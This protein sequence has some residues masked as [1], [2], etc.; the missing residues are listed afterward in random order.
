MSVTHFMGAV[1]TINP[2]TKQVNNMLREILGED[3]CTETKA[4]CAVSDAEA[5]S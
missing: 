3:R 2:A 1:Y 5:D 4:G